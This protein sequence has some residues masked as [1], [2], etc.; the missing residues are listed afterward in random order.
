MPLVIFKASLHSQDMRQG[1]FGLS[2]TKLRVLQENSDLLGFFAAGFA[3][4]FNSYS[5]DNL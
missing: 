3:C 2:K 1:Y 4:D 5:C